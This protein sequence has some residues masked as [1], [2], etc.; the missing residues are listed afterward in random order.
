MNTQTGFFLYQSIHGPRMG[1]RC[2]CCSLFTVVA[3]GA[4]PRVYHCNGYA[5]YQKPKPTFWTWLRGADQ[6]PRVAPSAPVI[7]RRRQEPED[8][9]L[10][11]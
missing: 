10:Q 3:E 1:F 5:E 9:F 7:L 6:L 4:V 2:S 11:P 8:D